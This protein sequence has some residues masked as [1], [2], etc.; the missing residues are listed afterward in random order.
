M[1]L[2]EATLKA[3]LTAIF[4]DVSGTTGMIKASQMSTAIDTHTKT[5]IPMTT[6]TGSVAAGQAVAAWVTTSP[7]VLNGEGEGG[8]DSSSPGSGLSDGKDALKADLLALFS[9]TD[10]TMTAEKSATQM[11]AAITKYLKSAK[12]M[13]KL[14]GVWLPGVAVTPIFMPPS[15]PLGT[16]TLA[17]GPYTAVGQGGLETSDTGSGLDKTSNLEDIMKEM[18]HNF[19]AMP[20]DYDDA[21]DKWSNMIHNYYSTANVMTTDMGTAG[22][23]SASVTA[24]II[25]PPPV[26][27]GVGVTTA[28]S[29]VS[30]GTGTGSIS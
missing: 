28:P 4:V 2:I 17:V 21:A 14:T 10:G 23:G 25:G 5:G 30:T 11:A 13:T 3:S 18:L 27:G 26:P 9:T 7:G 19:D 8:I 29:D 16:S 24:N 20:V 15:P 6:H 22:G 1:P 12:V